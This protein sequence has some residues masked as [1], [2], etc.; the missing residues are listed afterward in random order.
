VSL[1]ELVEQRIGNL[2]RFLNK[3]PPDLEIVKEICLEEV[4]F[5]RCWK[6]E[7]GSSI[8][9]NY[10]VSTLTTYRNAIKEQMGPDYKALENQWRELKRNRRQAVEAVYKDNPDKLSKALKE[11]DEIP[12]IKALKEKLEPQNAHGYALRYLKAE[13]ELIQTFNSEIRNQMVKSQEHQTELDEENFMATTLEFLK[14][15][16]LVELFLGLMA[17]TGRRNAEIMETGEFTLTEDPGPYRFAAQ[18]RLLFKG[19]LKTRSV[20]KLEILIPVLAPVELVLSA[21]D[22]FRDA[23][24]QKKEEGKATREYIMYHCLPMIRIKYGL[25]DDKKVEKV[26]SVYAHLA[27]KKFRPKTVSEDVFIA[28]IL[29]QRSE[30]FGAAQYYKTV[31]T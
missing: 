22:K 12:E 19:Q 5:L 16:S 15:E 23:M 1:K 24:A 6:K 25:G 3:N 9:L 8:S 14:S 4:N 27:A 29:G 2:L 17:A 11:I 13:P 28:D 10:L 18:Y 31:T 20:E 30:S 21:F 26:R 7:D